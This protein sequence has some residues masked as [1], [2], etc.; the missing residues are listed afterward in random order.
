[1]ARTL[2][3]LLAVV[4]L[5]PACSS[6]SV[7]IFDKDSDAGG[8]AGGSGGGVLGGSDAGPA[9]G[10]G[11]G[12]GD[13]G[14]ASNGILSATI[15]DFKLY[16]A[17][18]PTT[19]PDFENVPPGGNGP[20]DDREIVAATLGMDGKPVYKNPTGTTL[21]THG[22][23][24]FD[25][26]YRDVA[27]TNV[28]LAYPMPLAPNADGSFSFDSNVTG[29]PLSA[30][31]PRKNFFPI[32]DGSPY[33][34][35]F[36]NQGDPHNYS[37]TVELHTTFTYKGGEFFS[38]RGDDDVFVFVNDQLVINVGGIHEPELADVKIDSLGL[39][40]G[41]EYRLDFFS[42][43]RHKILSNILFTTTLGLRPAPPR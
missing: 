9:F 40:K 36:G 4:S 5:A 29:V 33:A 34:T 26:W 25:R 23:D 16:N 27:G 11:G 13:T 2:L 28:T 37:F 39:T 17:G 24:A 32:D 18:D 19:D 8:G 30:S 41:Q 1:M 15:R 14:A 22:K 38:F 21:T 6:N 42:A 12:G 20:W 10:D 3:A 7:S 35:A 31:D 43:E